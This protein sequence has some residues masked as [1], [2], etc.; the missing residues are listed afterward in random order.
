VLHVRESQR[1]PFKPGDR[2]GISIIERESTGLRIEK[3]G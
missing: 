3:L 2:V 1:L